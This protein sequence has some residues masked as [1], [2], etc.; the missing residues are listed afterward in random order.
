MHVNVFQQSVAQCRSRRKSVLVCD[1]IF[2]E[3]CHFW[4]VFAQPSAEWMEID[5]QHEQSAE[6]AQK[7][8]RLPL[9]N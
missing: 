3:K 6:G 2:H 9:F 5:P 4:S 8:P 7:G 1:A